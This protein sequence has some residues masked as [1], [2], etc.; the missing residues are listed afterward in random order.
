MGDTRTLDL[1][2]SNCLSGRRGFSKLSRGREKGFSVEK[3]CFLSK[4]IVFLLSGPFFTSLSRFKWVKKCLKK[5]YFLLKGNQTVFQIRRN[6][7]TITDRSC[8]VTSS[9][10][11]SP[12]VKNCINWLV[13]YSDIFNH[14]GIPNRTLE[15]SQ[16]GAIPRHIRTSQELQVISN[17]IQIF[18]DPE[19]L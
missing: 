14:S 11:K 8:L 19:D 16:Y 7:R 17:F 5:N 13:Q 18:L 15:I 3:S 4:I 1:D 9:F 10:F 12:S 2:T 6:S